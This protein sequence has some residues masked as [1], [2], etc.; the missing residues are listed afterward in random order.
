[1][2]KQFVFSKIFL[3]IQNFQNLEEK[4]LKR[5]G[6]ADKRKQKHEESQKS[7]L[8]ASVAVESV[9]AKPVRRR[10]R[11]ISKFRISSLKSV[12]LDAFDTPSVPA[13]VR[14]VTQRL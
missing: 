11:S 9:R 5:R 2:K 14:S 7:W 10:R 12:S 8:I 13:F 4:R 6:A 1:M 3:K